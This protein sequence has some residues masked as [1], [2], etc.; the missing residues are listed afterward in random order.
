MTH[1]RIITAIFFLTVMNIHADE[2]PAQER[3]SSSYTRF[4]YNDR[5]HTFAETSLRVGIVYGLT[6][7][8]YP[9]VLPSE[10]RDEG[11]SRVWRDNF[12]RVVWDK[13]SP[14]WNWFIHPISGSQL[15]LF[16]RANGYTQWSS[17]GLTFISQA[18]WEFTVEIYT[19]PTS[20]EDN[21]VTTVW[22][23]ALGFGLERLS[24][25][26]LNYGTR[27]TRVLGHFINPSTLFWFYEGR[28][29]FQPQVDFR[30][31]RELYA[32][33]LVISF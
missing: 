11:S 23:S 12:G 5:D 17:V 24:M 25:Y 3:N 2:L 15:Y 7:A 9:L 21:Y 4:G 18:L 32:G 10:F 14:F 1:L 28:V 20:F 27:T 8:M 26:L 30:Q 29:H 19:E 22:G 16:Y 33:K 13:D 6:W 31:G